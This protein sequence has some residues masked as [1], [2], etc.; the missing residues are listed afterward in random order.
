MNKQI[1]TL[2]I[3]LGLLGGA[4]YYLLQ[5][6]AQTND[7]KPLLFP[8]LMELGQNIDRIRIANGQGVIVDA[9]RGMDG[10]QTS[11]KVIG[12]QYPLDQQALSELISSLSKARLL[13][14]KTARQDN[15]IHLGLQDLGQPDSQATSLSIRAGGKQ[16]EVLVGI[17]A[18]SG[19]GRYVRLPNAQQTWLTNFDVSLPAT[20]VSWL[21]QPILDI[22]SDQIAKISRLDSAQFEIVASIAEGIK[23]TLQNID[24]G[25]PLQYDTIVDGFVNNLAG[26]NFEQIIDSLAIDWQ[27]DLLAHYQIELVDDR[28]IEL[29]VKSQ[30]DLHYAQFMS[31][32]S[33]DAYWDGLSYQIS[34]FA[35]Q[36]LDKTSED[37]VEQP[38]QEVNP[39]V[40]SM[41]EGESPQ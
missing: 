5:N 23:F 18:S 36:Q 22:E 26:L 31:Q 33:T 20:E 38:V 14:K 8:Q 6:A 37:F 41:D 27:Q 16:F 40:P 39:A 21:K 34:S 29:R 7:E 32:Q 35:I 9:T 13:E 1:V 25:L 24:S 28:V 15:F 4:I 19:Q 11:L 12:G 30:G 2:L 10:W 17:N 3:I